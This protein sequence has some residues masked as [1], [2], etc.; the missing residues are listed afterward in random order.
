M[1]GKANARGK[2]H[3]P[4]RARTNGRRFLMVSEQACSRTEGRT[5]WRG[6]LRAV[7]GR[8]LC[9][10]GRR[11]GGA[12]HAPPGVRVVGLR[13]PAPVARKPGQGTV[14]APAASLLLVRGDGRG[15]P[16]R[17]S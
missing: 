13:G 15:A 3:Y 16:K 6:S 1:G 5:V 11:Y 9:A 2:L 7:R 12:R 14:R 4:K 10:S 17:R 8:G